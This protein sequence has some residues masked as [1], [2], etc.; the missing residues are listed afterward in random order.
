M[1]YKVLYSNTFTFYCSKTFMSSS[2]LSSTYPEKKSSR[3]LFVILLIYSVY[4]LLAYFNRTRSLCKKGEIFP[5]S[6]FFS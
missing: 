2:I 5:L 1:K 6:L 3:F 4:R